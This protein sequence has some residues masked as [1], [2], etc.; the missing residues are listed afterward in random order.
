MKIRKILILFCLGGGAYTGLELAFRGWSHPSM[1]VLGGICFLL[2]GHLGHQV[3]KPGL[4]SRSLMGAAICTFGE[5][6]FGMLFNRGYEIWD[7]RGQPGNFAGQI[8]P[9]FSLLWIP[10]SALAAVLYAWAEGRL[11]RFS[12]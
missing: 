11:E 6:L 3:P 9:V 12:I 10:V 4:L 1:F 2:I 8:C 7:Y 5:L